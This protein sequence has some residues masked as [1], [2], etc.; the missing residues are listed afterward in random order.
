MAKDTL[1]HLLNRQLKYLRFFSPILKGS[2]HSPVSPQSQTKH[3]NRETPDEHELARDKGWPADQ[4]RLVET[5]NLRARSDC[6]GRALFVVWILPVAGEPRRTGNGV[7]RISNSASRV[8]LC[9]CFLDLRRRD[10]N[11]TAGCS[12]FDTDVR[13]VLWVR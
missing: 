4:I 2:P 12:R 11:V 3:A 7:E 9:D 13:L 6:S 1:F 5:R 10:W 8:S